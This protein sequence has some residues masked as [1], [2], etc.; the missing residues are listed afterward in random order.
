VLRIGIRGILEAAGGL[1]SIAEAGTG[2]EAAAA[3]PAVQPTLIVVQDALP[4]VT[5][6]V[7]A[8][9]LR[10]MAPTARLIV[11]TDEVDDARVVEAIGNGVDA[12]LP[13]AIDGATLIGAI[14]QL[15]EG[16][17]PLN[18]HVLARPDLAARILDTVRAEAGVGN[19]AGADRLERISLLMHR[20]RIADGR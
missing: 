7:A 10:E 2:L 14:R 19:A 1:A 5:G 16:R 12:L 6:V 4:G 8:R 18:D 20:R 13:S 15:E 3:M 17:R 11:L 9:M